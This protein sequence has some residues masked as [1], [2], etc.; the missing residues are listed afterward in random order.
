MRKL[1]NSMFV[2]LCGMMIATTFVAC[3]GDD[4]DNGG[5]LLGTWSGAEP[6][7]SSEE[8]RLTFQNGGAGTFVYVQ[9]KKKTTPRE[10]E[11]ENT[12]SFTY[13]STSETTGS[14]TA[15]KY[16]KSDPDDTDT[17]NY[18]ISGKTMNLYDSKH[19]DDLEYVLTKQ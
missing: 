8:V 19:P 2:I 10:V 6:G 5:G 1:I 16:F 13:V 18:V 15:P 3:G 7:T 4:D 11:T 14:I 9:Y 17:Y 12:G